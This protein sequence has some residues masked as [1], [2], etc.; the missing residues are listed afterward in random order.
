MRTA[1]WPYRTAK[2]GVPGEPDR[3]AESGVNGVVGVGKEGRG[4]MARTEE[5]VDM[6]IVLRRAT[7]TD[8]VDRLSGLTRDS[9]PLKGGETTSA[10]AET[11]DG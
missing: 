3:E 2:Y 7:L 4:A 11:G 1:A 10:L 9:L 6:L 8:E 5:L